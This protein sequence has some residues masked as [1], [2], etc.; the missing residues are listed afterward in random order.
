MEL[1]IENV[2]QIGADEFYR[3]SRYSLALSVIIVN[4]DD[5]NAFNIFEENT[6]QTDIVQQLSSESLVIFL[7]HT[8]YDAATLFFKTIENKLVFTH[9]IGEFKDSELEFITNLFI[10]NSNE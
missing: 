5:N 2:L 3:A 10:K 8:G 4:S 9:T 6:R 7:P 1:M